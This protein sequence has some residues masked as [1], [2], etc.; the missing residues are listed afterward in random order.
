MAVDAAGTERAAASVATPFSASA[1]GVDMEVGDLERVVTEVIVAL[2]PARPRIAAVGISGLAESGAPFAAGR[3]TGPIIAWHDGRGEETVAS[4]QRRFG[5]SLARRTGRRLRT[6]SSVAKLGWLL[7]HGLPVPD[8]WLGVPEVVLWL[9]TG[10]AATEH[11][12]A[13]RTGAYDVIERRF[14]PEVVDHL[15]GGAGGGDG[16]G[17][18]GRSLFPSVRRAGTVM[19]TVSETAVAGAGLPEG[20]PVTLA[21]HD[22]LAAAAG[23]GARPDDLLNSV[24]TAETVLRRVD[25]PPDVER[26]LELELAVTVWPGGEGWGVLASCTR[27][28]LVVGALAAHLGLDPDQLDA[29]TAAGGG[30][31]PPGGGGEAVPLGQGIEV[32]AGSPAAMWTATLRAL[33][34]R[35]AA[36]AERVRALAGPHARVV[37]FGGGSRSPVWQRAKAG[38]LD[39]P[40]VQSPVQEAAALGAARAAGA[41]TGWWRMGGP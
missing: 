35:T 9:L 10:S 27:S 20:I 34:R 1:A 38:A 41:A 3:P 29:L 5:P 25:G 36:A 32:P 28:G 16:A 12:L 2:G 33:S 24:G 13:A 4:L 8:R 22:H 26:A 37:V 23:V 40:V 18:E 15:L 39:V 30:D 11:S 31:E 6:V 14:L 7:D 19:G 17:R 21:G